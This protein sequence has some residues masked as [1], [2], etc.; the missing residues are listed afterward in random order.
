MQMAPDPYKVVK[1]MV[2]VRLIEN[3]V[4]NHVGKVYVTQKRTVGRT[5]NT[6]ST[7]R[8]KSPKVV[9]GGCSADFMAV[10]VA[11]RAPIVLLTT[12]AEVSTRDTS[13]P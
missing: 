4:N 2:N 10:A 5:P 13:T 3:S 11:L 6:E 12:D 7:T 8:P 1:F 9:E